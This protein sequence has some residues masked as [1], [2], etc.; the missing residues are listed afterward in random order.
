MTR[1]LQDS[2]GGAAQAIMITC[3][4]PGQQFY[5]DTYHALNISKKS[6]TIVNKPAVN[7]IENKSTFIYYFITY[8][9]FIEF[10]LNCIFVL[11]LSW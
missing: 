11:L 8:F 10:Y 6:K 5:Q 2:L 7:E 3:V 4:A 1:F 9:S